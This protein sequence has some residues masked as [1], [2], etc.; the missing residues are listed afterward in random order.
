MQHT[1]V[2]CIDAYSYKWLSL[3]SNMKDSCKCRPR[4]QLWGWDTGCLCYNTTFT[5]R[6]C[7]RIC[8]GIQYRVFYTLSREYRVVRNRYSRLLFTG[9][10]RLLRQI[11]RARTIDEYD[12]EMLVPHVRETSQ[13]NCGDVTMLSQKRPSSAKM[14]K[15]AIDNCFS[16][17]VCSGHK[18]ECKKWNNTFV[19][20]NNDF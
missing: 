6:L 2:Q 7:F 20:V 16:E 19:T 3:N 11:A 18:I 1:T 4:T 5:P 13:I 10:D 8:R 9:E 17:I 14:A 15:S 12:V